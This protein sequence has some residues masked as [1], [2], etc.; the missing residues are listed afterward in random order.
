MGEAVSTVM[1]VALL[2]G[3]GYIVWRVVRRRRGKDE[4]EGHPRVG[5]V[6]AA[7]LAFVVIGT[8]TAPA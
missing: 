8:I 1:F 3:L 5:V 6:I 7:C 2:A 4:P